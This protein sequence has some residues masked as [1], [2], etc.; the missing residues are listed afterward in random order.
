MQDVSNV[1]SAYEQYAKVGEWQMVKKNLLPESLDV[2]VGAL[3]IRH[4]VDSPKG[5]YSTG[6]GTKILVDG[7]PLEGVRR[8]TLYIACDDAIRM[9]IEQLVPA[10]K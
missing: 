5:K 6:V 2:E 10:K 7:K 4:S 9:E 1:D 3:E 8:L